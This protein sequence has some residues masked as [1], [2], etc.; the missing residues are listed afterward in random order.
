MEA[1]LDVY[2]RPYDINYPVVCMD[3]SPKQILDYKEFT[4]TTGKK[5]Q[6]SEYVRLGVAELFVAFEPLA[7]YR[8]MTVEND[9]SGGPS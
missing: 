1:V 7:G 9:R 5:Y 2:E 6:D 4:G 3:E 8:N